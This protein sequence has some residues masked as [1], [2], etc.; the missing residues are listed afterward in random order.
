MSIVITNPDILPNGTVG[1]AYSYQLTV[2]GD[3]PPDTWSVTPA[4]PAGLSLGSSSGIISGTPTAYGEYPN[5]FTVTVVDSLTNT[6]SLTIYFSINFA[7]VLNIVGVTGENLTNPPGG[8]NWMVPGYQPMTATFDGGTTINQARYAFTVKN[9][10]TNPAARIWL[11]WDL[12]VSWN[13]AAGLIFTFG[14][15]A[16]GYTHYITIGANTYS[17]VDTGGYTADFI[18]ASL[19][20]AVNASSTV[21]FAIATGATVGLTAVGDP[22][23]ISCSA[24]DGNTSGTIPSDSPVCASPIYSP[25]NQMLYDVRFNS[26]RL[27]A[28]DATSV[29]LAYISAASV[30]T[31]P[32]QIYFL[33]QYTVKFV[34]FTFGPPAGVFSSAITTLTIDNLS[35]DKPLIISSLPNGNIV[36]VYNTFTNDGTNTN[37]PNYLNGPIR[38]WVTIYN[39]SSWSGP[40]E[41]DGRET[42]G[43]GL[44]AL[45]NP[46][47]GYTT[48]D[49]LTLGSGT[50]CVVGVGVDGGGAITSFTRGGS[51]GTGYV[52]GTFPASGGTGLGATF[53]IFALAW[54]SLD[55]GNILN[56]AIVDNG[57]N[58]H[59]LYN[60]ELTSSSPAY[61]A[62][63]DGSGA[64]VPV[65]GGSTY[66]PTGDG[67]G[68]Q[69]QIS[70]GEIIGQDVFA[71]G[72]F[73]SGNLTPQ[74]AWTFQL[75]SWGGGVPS[76]VSAS[77]L[78]IYYLGTD[79]TTTNPW[80]VYQMFM[81]YGV[82]AALSS[83]QFW[84]ILWWNFSQNPPPEGPSTPAY[85]R[86]AVFIN[87]VVNFNPVVGGRNVTISVNNGGS[88]YVMDFLIPGATPPVLSIALATAGGVGIAT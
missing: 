63:I 18:A 6:A 2:T 88:Y 81:N 42:S 4:L 66:A 14:P 85:G 79:P 61:S 39:G 40:T 23:P 77:P 35:V 16:G 30:V 49:N 80:N 43:V 53:T 21:A 71:I 75:T 64:V 11:S 41:I 9:P 82:W 44:V 15:Q 62:Y 34:S 65:G 50:G 74:P 86:A 45:A 29:T 67:I 17:L 10:T 73:H 36:F 72:V 27:N 37:P 19:A 52:L 51:A 31:A 87:M 8:M 54:A 69:Y 78:S 84:S 28:N 24:S 13:N 25:P 32:P 33:A 70:D 57:G 22:S 48:G 47:S 5:G 76:W 1:V 83:G 59:V 20:N 68:N 58:T 55:E 38:L 12:G 56:G 7:P 46:G 60:E 26:E 3:T